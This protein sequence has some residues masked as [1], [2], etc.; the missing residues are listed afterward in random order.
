ME[1]M[2]LLEGA[3]SPDA[4]TSNGTLMIA[5][6]VSTNVDDG[7]NK[8]FAGGLPSYLA[9]EQVKEL[10]GAFGQLKSFNLVK[11]SQT[12]NSKGFAF[13][14]YSDP[15]VTD[16]AC[17]GLNGMKLGEKTILVQRAN[18]G[19]KHH[20]PNPQGVSVLHN[21]TAFHFL[22]LGMPIAAAAALLAI[23]MT[24][25]G[26]PTCVVQLINVI[27]PADFE[28]DDDFQ[29]ILEELKEEAAKYGTV[30]S[31]Y[32]P[33]PMKRSRDEDGNL[34]PLHEPWWSVGRVF[35]EYRTVEEAQAALL[36]IGGRRFS[37]HTVIAGY[38]PEDRYIRKDFLPDVGEELMCLDAFKKRQQEKEFEREMEDDS[39]DDDKKKDKDSKHKRD[40]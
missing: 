1:G 21:P 12:G 7:P 16:R 37:G 36:A 28:N 18:V 27:S 10:V 11:D 29:E 15:D 9:E 33:R 22:N 34:L 31:I 40:K 13:Y 2:P 30:E 14:E 23:N 32:I 20:T 39:D 26:P 17:A 38:F 19:A 3:P 24:D 35:L 8:I 6:I 25:P 4:I 5:N